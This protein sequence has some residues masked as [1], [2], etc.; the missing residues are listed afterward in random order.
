M[1]LD[2]RLLLSQAANFIILLIVLRVFAY[3]PIL[4]LIKDR[5][6]RIEEGLEKAEEADRRLDQANEMVAGKMKEADQQ[7]MAVLRATESKS[8]ELEAKLLEEAKRKQAEV[9]ASTDQLIQGKAQEAK[10]AMEAE[11]A[12]MVKEA[13]VATV[14][15]DPKAIDEALVE[16]A[17]KSLKARA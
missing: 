5:R 9:L 2:W 8:K 12:R 14:E 10:K 13:L 17:V 3:K 7:A 15:M 16:K 6:A 11:A 1:G 4:K